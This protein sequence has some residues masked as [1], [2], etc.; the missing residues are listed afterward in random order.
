MLT[1]KNKKIKK[2]KNIYNWFQLSTSQQ[3]HGLIFI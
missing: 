2:N 3:E 1:K